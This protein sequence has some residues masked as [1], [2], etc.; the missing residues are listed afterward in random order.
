[1]P[2]KCF[3]CLKSQT[4][5][6]VRL[7]YRH[8][9]LTDVPPEVFAFERTLEELYLD[10]NRI[11][12]LPRPLFHCHGL[13]HLGLSD[14]EIQSIPAAISSLI[15]LEHLDISKNGISGIPDSIKGCKVLATVDASVNPLEK[16]PEGFMQLIALEE[17]YLNDAY[18]EFLPAN[19]GRLQKL[20]ILE[21]RE[22]HLNTLPK[23][24]ARLVNLQRLDIGQNEFSDVPE[25]VGQLPNITELWCDFNRIR[26][27]PQFVGNLKK[28][29]H[30]DAS[31]NNI[32]WVAS[33][34][35]NCQKLCDLTLSGNEI[36][37]IPGSLG[38]LKNLMTLKL[39]D[40]QLSVL[41]E[42]IGKMSSLEELILSQNDFE[43]LPPSIGL[44]RRLHIL[45]VD[46][47]MLED[48]P[49]EI[50][51]CCNLSILSVAGN[52]L[53]QIPG[54]I[55]HL[56]NLKVANL[57][58]NRLTN[59]PVSLL[60]L[61]SLAALWLSDNQAQPLVPLQ[62]DVDPLTGQR[63]LTCFMLPQTC[64][65]P[66]E[67][68][69]PPQVVVPGYIPVGEGDAEGD[70]RSEEE[71]IRR[72]HIRFAADSEL[73]VGGRLLR[74]P[75][76][77][78]KELRA[79]ARHARS[80]QR[81]SHATNGP[82]AA[83]P[84]IC[85]GSF[86]LPHQQEE[87]L[88]KRSLESDDSVNIKEEVSSVKKQAVTAEV[89]AEAVSEL[90]NVQ[91]RLNGMEDNSVSG[92]VIDAVEPDVKNKVEIS[93]ENLQIDNRNARTMPL[94]ENRDAL[95]VERGNSS[96]NGQCNGNKEELDGNMKLLSSSETPP[97]Q[98]P[99][100]YIAAAYSK[101]AAFFNSDIQSRSSISSLPPFSPPSDRLTPFL[102]HKDQVRPSSV[103]SSK[104]DSPQ[105]AFN[106]SSNG[107]MLTN[108]SK[109]GL[110]E[111]SPVKD[112]L[113]ELSE[114]VE[115]SL[116]E[117]GMSVE[118]RS[119]LVPNPHVEQLSVLASPSPK[120]TPS[121]SPVSPL[122]NTSVLSRLEATPSPSGGRKHPILDE[123]RSGTP[124]KNVT[125][126][127]SSVSGDDH[128][129]TYELYNHGN[130]LGSSPS[131]DKHH[132]PH[133]NSPTTSVPSENPPMSPAEAMYRVP[134]A[135]SHEPMERK[136]S[137]VAEVTNES[138]KTMTG[139]SKIPVSKTKL[140]PRSASE[141][142]RDVSLG[143]PPNFTQDKPSS[144]THL[145]APT[146]QRVNALPTQNNG[147]DSAQDLPSSLNN[148]F[149][150][151]NSSESTSVSPSRIPSVGSSPSTRSSQSWQ[152]T[153]PLPSFTS[154]MPP[155]GFSMNKKSSIPSPLYG[156]SRPVTS[157]PPVQTTEASSSP[158]P[159]L[160]ASTSPHSKIPHLAGV[161]SHPVASSNGKS[162]S[163]KV[164]D[165]MDKS[166]KSMVSSSKIPMLHSSRLETSP[167]TDIPVKS[168][169]PVSPQSKLS[170]P[171]KS[172]MFG[173]HKNAMVFP[174]SIHKN[175]GL[176]FSIAG[177]HHPNA[178]PDRQDNGIFITKVH[179][180][181][182]ASGSLLPGDKILE[183]DGI[184]FTKLE[185][186]QAVSILTQT[187]NV[188]QM[189][190][191]RHQ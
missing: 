133:D 155:P 60:G 1:M 44:L 144:G 159:R 160:A 86:A 170:P 143:R 85:Q 140:A 124:E 109:T 171:S 134:S 125:P 167:A 106:H 158:Q 73:D 55:G 186:D 49:P 104:Y 150:S 163:T 131:E 63:V 93:N 130:S 74:A 59:L 69:T 94:S 33:D 79:L 35:E 39:D 50:G 114:R 78:P 23:S 70:A 157:P 80:L 46:E 18:L 154:K 83:P 9:T 98:P 2:W 191:S 56:A 81:V 178:S 40:N 145:I 95:A 12:D 41:P 82:V 66:S 165:P 7:D 136:G 115:A 117:L 177:G 92:T 64:S 53:V 116:N 10:A 3:G 36:Q 47:N 29:V 19:F 71:R 32:N 112:D 189:M 180:N 168:R 149:G 164:S 183:V 99:P 126:V 76:P 21:L 89:F 148:S 187:G 153:S 182:P 6:I 120:S 87:P 185:H 65:V 13:R 90:S 91:S 184:D 137:F 14:N 27:I 102:D 54:E 132:I 75:T 51:S 122:Q 37:E 139:S 108:F 152:R 38:N 162:P 127:A 30:L 128:T 25:V 77:Y 52:R 101:K 141:E 42:S 88:V 96:H 17:L 135:A 16:L 123:I 181:G 111:D 176:G 138:S 118:E 166:M 22:N 61:S 43:T 97:Q 8:C 105:P 4:E 62:P 172:W 113:E 190:I 48:L 121:P 28:L 179:P 68:R 15:N 147:L 110:R 11:K 161:A 67:V 156:N 174:V 151:G 26:S 58:G 188:V 146:P 119:F 175:P 129:S 31:N 45:N 100:Y 142:M 84:P 72:R 20:R 169:I 5:D 173:L 107:S 34:V 103:A 57:S 24:I